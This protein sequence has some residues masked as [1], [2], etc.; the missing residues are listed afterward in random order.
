MEKEKKNKKIDRRK[1]SEKKWR[2][3]RKVK[4]RGKNSY[5]DFNG[6]L[7]WKWWVKLRVMG[8]KMK[9][10]ERFWLRNLMFIWEENDYGM[11]LIVEDIKGVDL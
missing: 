1:M 8:R 7:D 4:S 11:I 2:M 6:W 9:K 10:R 5:R 3:K